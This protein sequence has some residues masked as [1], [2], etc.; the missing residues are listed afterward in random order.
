M[1]YHY[2]QVE[3]VLKEGLWPRFGECSF[4]FVLEP[5]DDRATRL[6]VRTRFTLGGPFFEVGDFLQ[7]WRM[8][9]GIKR[10]A[11]ALADSGNVPLAT[12]PREDNGL[13]GADLKSAAAEHA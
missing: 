2:P 12:S 7:Q 6:M 3:W 1:A 13:A 8:L 10:R 4:V 5:A 9:P 11:E